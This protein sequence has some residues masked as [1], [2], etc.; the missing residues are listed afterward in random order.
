[1]HDFIILYYIYFVEQGKFE[2]E[3]LFVHSASI[4]FCQS[5]TS[6]AAAAAHPVELMDS[7]ICSIKV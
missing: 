1:M 6:L 5:S 2:L 4:S 3:S 7:S